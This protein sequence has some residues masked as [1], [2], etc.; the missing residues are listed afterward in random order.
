MKPDSNPRARPA[1]TPL[2]GNGS[3][4]AIAYMDEDR[5]VVDG[6]KTYEVHLPP[7]VPDTDS[8]SVTLHDNET[9]STL[10]I[11]KQLESN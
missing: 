8:W 6:S 11:E 9:R 4:Y 5:G 3:H 10:Q 2:I 7:D 1:S